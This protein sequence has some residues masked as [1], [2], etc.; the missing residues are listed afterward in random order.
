MRETVSKLDIPIA[1]YADRHSIF[2]QGKE[3]RVR[4]LSLE[5]K[6][7]AQRDP[8]QFGRLMNELGV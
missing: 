5:E 4:K 8:T 3:V 7:A 6:L 1:I 2:F